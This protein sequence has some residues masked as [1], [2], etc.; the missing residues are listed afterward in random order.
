MC[1]MPGTESTTHPEMCVFE[2]QTPPGYPYRSEG[3]LRSAVRWEGR[4]LENPRHGVTTSSPW[5]PDQDSGWD[6]G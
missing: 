3:G 2:G 6:D 5:E 4:P 1:G